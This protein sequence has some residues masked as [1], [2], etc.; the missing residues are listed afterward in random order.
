MSIDANELIKLIR[1]A[2][3]A[4]VSEMKYGEL[5]IKFGPGEAAQSL[6][7]A[8]ETVEPPTDKELEQ[9]DEASRKEEMLDQADEELAHMQV[10][11]PA[12]FEEMLIQRELE[13]SGDDGRD[14]DN[15]D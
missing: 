7:P 13:L 3:K 8:G 6:V 14:S 11:N 1:A 10:E 2:K 15:A 9:V 4:G 5:E 12:L